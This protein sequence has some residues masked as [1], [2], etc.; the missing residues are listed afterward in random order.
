[1]CERGGLDV[2]H[3]NAPART[4]DGQATQHNTCARQVLFELKEYGASA[5]RKQAADV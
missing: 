2:R 3:L 1:M 5:A 4:P